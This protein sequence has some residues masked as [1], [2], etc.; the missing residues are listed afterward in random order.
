MGWELAGLEAAGLLGL[1]GKWVVVWARVVGLCLT[2]PGLAVPGLAW[3]SRLG[4]A[5]VLGAVL[6][7]VVTPQVPPPADWPA[8]VGTG[9]A[10]VVTGGVLG[11]SAGLIVAAARAAGDLV[12]AQAGLATA[13]LFD[14]ESG[15]EQ[16]PLG[17]LYGWLAL[18]VFLAMDGPIVLVRALVDSYTA[19]PPGQL[20]SSQQAVALAFGQVGHA[21][22]LALRLAAPPAIALVMTGIVLGWLSRAAPSL[23]FF[24]LALPIRAG[25]GI[26]LILLSMTVL[27]VTLAGA[28]GQ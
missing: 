14:P 27:V 1:A 11:W 4:L 9:L 6:A 16:T 10:E 28:W 19:I 22:E 5:A 12:A 3:Q 26:A 8:A 25:L 24:T 20:L 7:P 21:L 13:M 23:P 18:A 17:Q 15:E 2:A